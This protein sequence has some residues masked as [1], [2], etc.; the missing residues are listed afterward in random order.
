[1][2]CKEID[3]RMQYFKKAIK[4]SEI[5]NVVN[6]TGNYVTTDEGAILTV[7]RG[8]AHLYGI[9]H[10][11]ANI[12]VAIRDSLS[13]EPMVILQ[14]R[15]NDRPIFPN[16]LTVSCGGHMGTA[17]DP[18]KAVLREATEEL[19]LHLSAD[20]LI[21]LGDSKVGY[22]NCLRIWNYQGLQLIQMGRDGQVATPTSNDNKT[23]VDYI[24][25]LSPD[26]LPDENAPSGLSLE[27]FNQEFCFYYLVT[28]NEAEISQ[29][30]FVDKEVAG[31]SRIDL[32][33]FVNTPR[34]ELTDSS[35]ILME[36]VPDLTGII[37]SAC[38]TSNA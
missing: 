36:N 35:L 17:I 16:A 21:P 37:R 1:M 11:T 23:A 12:L 8:A 27:V 30:D 18:V 7:A 28:L 20:R 38:N 29:I 9:I 24:L 34:H 33:K 32:M 22:R 2:F 19:K 5:L 13:R 10:Q 31:I 15:A 26:E 25:S 3:N 6:E 4:A 14:R